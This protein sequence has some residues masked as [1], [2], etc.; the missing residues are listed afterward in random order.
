MPNRNPLTDPRPAEVCES[1]G[2]FW[3]ADE[4]ISCEYCAD[5]KMIGGCCQGGSGNTCTEHEY[6]EEDDDE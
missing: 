2:G 3:S 1:C 6:L 5:G 4:M